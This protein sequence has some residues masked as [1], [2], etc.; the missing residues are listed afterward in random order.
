[1]LWNINVTTRT[2]MSLF[3]ILGLGCFATSCAIVRITY[4][5]TYGMS[6]DWLWDTVDLA[7]WSVVELNISIIAGSLP[8]LRPLF[9]KFLGTVYGSGSRMKAYYGH[10]GSASRTSRKGT[11]QWQ[12]FSMTDGK[13]S[14][15]SRHVPLV[16]TGRSLDDG[17][18]QV[19]LNEHM[20]GC[21]PVRSQDSF[22]LC[23]YKVEAHIT[24]ESPPSLVR[25]PTIS[26]G[27]TKTTTTTVSYDDPRSV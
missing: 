14:K 3:F 15:N 10:G 24:T 2:K 27:I 8:S 9:K 13:K 5:G 22:E 12:P 6:G 1:M 26:G 18:S 23:S 20:Q 16:P 11:K 4:L 19:Q 17:S 25:K 7:T 21:S